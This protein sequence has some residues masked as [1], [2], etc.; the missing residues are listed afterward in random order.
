MPI[1]WIDPWIGNSSTS[2]DWGAGTTSNTTRDGSYAS[3]FKWEDWRSNTNSTSNTVNG[4]TVAANTEIRIKG[5]TIADMFIDVGEVYYTGGSSPKMIATDTSS[6]STAHT[7]ANDSSLYNSVM[8]WGIISGTRADVIHKDPTGFAPM[9]QSYRYANDYNGVISYGIRIDNTGQEE[10]AMLLDNTLGSLDASQRGYGFLKLLKTSEYDASRQ[11]LANGD[12]NYWFNQDNLIKMSA[13]WTSETEQNGISLISFYQSDSYEY[14]RFRGNN[15]HWDCQ[16]LTFMNQSPR[17][18]LYWYLRNVGATHK[19]GHVDFN[20]GTI[21]PYVYVYGSSSAEFGTVS[22]RVYFDNNSQSNTTVKVHNAWNARILLRGNYGTGSKFQIGNYYTRGYIQVSPAQKGLIARQGQGFSTVEFLPNSTYLAAVSSG[23][24]TN[25]YIEVPPAEVRVLSAKS[26]SYSDPTYIFGTGLRSAGNATGTWLNDVTVDVAPNCGA[27]I[28]ANEIGIYQSNADFYS[29]TW[30]TS[31]GLDLSHINSNPMFAHSVPCG[32]LQLNGSDY[33]TNNLSVISLQNYGYTSNSANYQPMVFGFETND[34]DQK[35]VALL[36]PNSA[37]GLCGLAYNETVSGTEYLVLKTGGGTGSYI[38]PVE[39]PVPSHTAGSN[40][41]RLK[42][43]AYHYTG[44]ASASVQMLAFYRKDDSSNDY[45]FVQDD[46]INLVSLGS[47][48]SSPRVSYLNI[49]L[50]AS[51]VREINSIM[52]YLRFYCDTTSH[53]NR[54]YIEY[55]I[56]ETY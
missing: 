12:G 1:V 22:G 16:H 18:R 24:S 30:W 40:N 11:L 5:K 20:G 19:F 6:G 17:V 10:L 55:V 50:S 7:F 39:V 21:Q 28:S 38:Y 49:P 53:N 37:T 26:T 33:R 14:Q 48:S 2:S 35:P 23:S 56:S 31:I 51:G 29:S 36:P 46:T 32:K 34:Y 25:S 47:D 9:L 3:P 54:A 13:G 15:L 41:I 42:I 27:V 43:R 8:S 4:Q 52:V 44:A 45:A